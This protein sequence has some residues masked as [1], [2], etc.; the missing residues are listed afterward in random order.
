MTERERIL[1][2]LNG[3]KP[4]KLPWCADLAYYTG[5]LEAENIYPEQYKNTYYDNGLQKMHRDYGTGFYLQGFSPL[6]A[7]SN[8]VDIKI[9]QQG[10]AI[11]KTIVTPLG[12][13]REVQQ[14]SK[15]SY[16][17]GIT[18][19]LIKDIKDLRCFC[20]L[21]E[22]TNYFADYDYAQKRYET[23]GDNGVV[24]CYTPKSPMM[25]LVALQSGIENFT[26]M[27]I[28]DEEELKELL[29]RLE[30]KCD[31]ACEIVVN[32]PA[33]C[34]MI[35]ENISSEC[36]TPFYQTYMERYHK[37]WTSKIHDK[38]KFSFVHIDGTVRGM[39]GELSRSGFDV[40]EAITPKPVGDVELE[41]VSTLVLDKTVIWGGIPGGFFTDTI[42]DEEFD[43]H[44]ISC[45]KTMTSSPRYVL[46]VADQIVPGSSVK[47]IKRVRELVDMYGSYS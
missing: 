6:K 42:S 18:E 1:S 27:A 2:I 30:V 39:V 10:N 40:V 33:E 47:R 23:I 22:H 45:I 9:E 4:D 25:E 20:Y 41:E 11:I 46:G 17:H 36:V 8:N 12:N 28:D 21:C 15:R 14:Y 13:L 35:P 5:Y 29:D 24:L 37:K 31:E 7:Q 16:S 38:G 3:K 34:I 32:S 19:H 26:Y 44:V 43:K